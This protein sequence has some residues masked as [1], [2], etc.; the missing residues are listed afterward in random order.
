MKNY[1]LNGLNLDYF[2]SKYNTYNTITNNSQNN[3]HQKE[4]Q[5]IFSPINVNVTNLDNINILELSSLKNNNNSSYGIKVKKLTTNL[6]MNY[7]PNKR[8]NLNK[9]TLV[10]DLDET[11]VHSSTVKP[12]PNQKNIIL[13]LKIKNKDYKIYVILR[14]FLDIFLKEMSAYYNLYIFTA[15]MAQYSTALLN[16]MDK[17]RLFIRSFNREHC[18]YQFGLYFKD[19][20]IFNVDYK[21]IIIIDNNPVSYALNKSNGIPIQTW[22]DDP[23]DKELIKLIPLLK[24]LSKVDDVRNVIK[25]IINRNKEKVNFTLFNKLLKDDNR[26]NLEQNKDKM[27]NNNNKHS[28]IKSNS[29]LN[30]DIKDSNNSNNLFSTTTKKKLNKK[31]IKIN[32]QDKNILK[33]NDNNSN[34][35]Y[36]TKKLKVKKYIRDKIPEDI[37]RTKETNTKPNIYNISIE[38]VKN[39]QNNIKIVLKD[40]NKIIISKLNKP[41]KTIKKINTFKKDEPKSININKTGTNIENNNDIIYGSTPL[42]TQVVTISK[43]LILNDSLS[44]L[45]KK[46]L[47]KN[48]NTIK[49]F[50]KIEKLNLK[51]ENL[52]KTNVFFNNTLRKNKNYY[53]NTNETYIPHSKGKCIVMKIIKSKTSRTNT[54]SNNK[55]FNN[56]LE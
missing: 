34:K 53:F 43:S 1:S 3:I 15:S 44:Y 39:I 36:T 7:F 48:E 17:N 50:P 12:F 23:Y 52:I 51:D 28:R 38:N 21:D 29:N 20:S 56:T 32:I 35:E 37:I 4:S 45:E 13:N 40:K 41:K 6:T 42:Q 16:I 54:S 25:K 24:Y 30:L 18:K 8:F 11:L 22:I 33:E 49:N 26:N 27:I 5:N 31:K 46:P 9:K 10:L 19:L 55:F 47:D 2:T 14:P